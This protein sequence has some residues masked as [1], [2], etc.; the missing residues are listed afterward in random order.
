MRNFTLVDLTFLLGPSWLILILSEVSLNTSSVPHRVVAY[1]GGIISTIGLLFHRQ[2]WATFRPSLTDLPDA[3]ILSE[4]N[5]EAKDRDW[6][7]Q[8]LQRL[9]QLPPE[10]FEKFVIYLL[11][12]YGLQL[13][14]TGASGDEGVDAIGTAPL[15]P[16]L[17]S[18]VAV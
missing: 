2:K 3:D 7:S 17:S 6:K 18:R 12:R 8:L 13:Q 14:H 15:S 16:V 4:S 5:E 10:G 11:R 9:H 1:F